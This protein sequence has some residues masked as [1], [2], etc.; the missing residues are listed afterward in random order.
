MIVYLNKV[1]IYDT[2]SRNSRLNFTKSV[3]IKEVYFKCLVLL[4]LSFLIFMIVPDLIYLFVGIINGNE[5]ETLL[6]A[7]WI[8]Y[9]VS[10]ITD[11][12]IY[13]FMQAP[14]RGY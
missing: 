8:S 4:I 9:A 13:I 2:M 14:V 12:L 6:T 3:A 1:S 11:G 7:C 10:M 5:T